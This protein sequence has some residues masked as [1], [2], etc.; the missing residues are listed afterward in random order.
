MVVGSVRRVH[1]REPPP[2]IARVAVDR[3]RDFVRTK[4]FRK[5]WRYVATSAIATL[6]SLVAL[7][8]FYRVVKVGSAG[9]ANVI[10]TAIATVPSYYLNRTWAWGKT[11]R[12]DLWREVIPFWVIAFVGLVLSTLAVDVASHEAHRLSQAHEVQTI[13]VEAAN[14]A[15]YG[16]L[17]VGKFLLFN[18]VL[19]KAAAPGVVAGMALSSEGRMEHP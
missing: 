6:V 2:S 15:T 4:E 9:E 18:R 17:W 14:L 8:L 7:Y 5:L 3:A 12:S 19:F 1:R 13:L 11:G 10:A 16:I